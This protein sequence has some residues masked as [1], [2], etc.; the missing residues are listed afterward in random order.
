MC[1]HARGER[2]LLK[3][4][5]RCG[6]LVVAIDQ[7]TLLH[8]G[9]AS[10]LTEALVEEEQV[11]RDPLQRRRVQGEVTQREVIMMSAPTVH[12]LQRQ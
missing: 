10:P 7:H 3:H 11:L 4:R 1:A 5:V 12:S 2:G 6:L 9:H 8:P